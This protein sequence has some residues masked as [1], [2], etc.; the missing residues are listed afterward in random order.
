MTIYTFTCYSVKDIRTIF[1]GRL[2]CQ[3]KLNSAL[4]LYSTVDFCY[5]SPNNF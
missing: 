4:K 2:C 1:H 5:A 3:K